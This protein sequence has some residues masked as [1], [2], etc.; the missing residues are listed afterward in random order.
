MV[1]SLAFSIMSDVAEELAAAEAKTSI[2]LNGL[3]I[4]HCNGV[5]R[6]RG[7][8]KVG[9][10][11]VPC[12]TNGEMH[13][14]YQ[15]DSEEWYINSDFTPS[16]E[17]YCVAYIS[18]RTSGRLKV[19][20]GDH[21]WTCVVDGA[22]GD[23]TSDDGTQISGLCW[24]AI[25]TVGEAT[26][27][28]AEDMSEWKRFL[29]ERCL[30]VLTKV[31]KAL[32]SNSTQNAAVYDKAAATKLRDSLMCRKHPQHLKKWPWVAV[33]NPNPNEQ[34]DVRPSDITACLNCL[35]STKS[36]VLICRT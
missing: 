9:T 29:T 13:L 6:Q 5:Y 20:M 27:G 34:K 22:S 17:E 33:L 16:I 8:L 18:G 11:D 10:M 36:C 15:A 30:G 35:H 4:A 12:Y 28:R 31:D 32:E 7:T 3:P 25:D 21:E 19:P 14:Y 1:A 23:S 24:V 2:T 26:T